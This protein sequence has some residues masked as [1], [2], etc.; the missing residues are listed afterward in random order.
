MLILVKKG[1]PI[2]TQG[3][4]EE[5]CGYDIKANSEPIILGDCME[6]PMEGLKLYRRID[7][8]EYRTGLFYC[9]QNIIHC[10]P[11]QTDGGQDLGSTVTKFHTHIFQRSSIFQKNLMLATGVSTIDSGYTG[12]IILNFRYIPQPEDMFIMP[13]DG[14]NRFFI[15]INKDKIY[16]K[17]D[18][19]AQ[20]VVFETHHADFKEMDELPTTVRGGRGFGSQRSIKSNL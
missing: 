12:E 11:D 14:M 19:I 20:L 17:D 10:H 9:P 18:K 2:P 13:Q 6:L 3:R 5:D 4:P 15:K 8:I 7:T 1:S 16:K